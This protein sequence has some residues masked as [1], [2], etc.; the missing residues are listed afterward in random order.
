MRTSVRC[1]LLLQ[2]LGF[3]I[4]GI[5]N[6]QDAFSRIGLDFHATANVNQTTF[7]EFWR[8][9]RGGGLTLTT[10]FYWGQLDIGT[11]VHR[12]HA[13]TE[14]PGFGVVWAYA[15][16]NNNWSLLRRVVVQPGLRLGLYR[17]SFDDAETSFYGVANETDLAV[18]AGLA[19]HFA[20]WDHIAVFARIDHLRIHTEPSLS[21]WYLS[22]G[23]AF[24]VAAGKRWRTF[25]E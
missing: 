13:K 3:G 6:S 7:H 24:D 22:S 25:W 1:G 19:V 17:M 2:F 20:L 8:S 9:G 4:T 16:L 5:A 10:P 23:M 15:G 12:Y 21:F 18:S 14:V 11:T